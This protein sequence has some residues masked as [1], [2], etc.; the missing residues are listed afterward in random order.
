MYENIKEEA[1]KIIEEGW[2]DGIAVL[3]G[4]NKECHSIYSGTISGT[5]FKPVS[6]NTVYDLASVTKIF[7]LICIL[8]LV[9]KGTLSL[10]ACVGDYSALFPNISGLKIYE[11]MNFSKPL[12]TTRRIDTANNY[13]EAVSLLHNVQFVDESPKYSDMG[14]IILSLILNEL[15]GASFRE[16]LSE[17]KEI[18]N[19]SNTFFWDEFTLEYA[20]R[21]QSYDKEYVFKDNKLITKNTPIG[22]PHDPKARI[23]GVCGHAGIFSTP[24]NIATFCQCL[25]SGKIVAKNTLSLVCS[26]KY[27]TFIDEQHFGLLCYKKSTNIK[28]SEVPASFSN[29]S[30]AIFG[31]TGTYI[32]ID[33]EY[34]K[35]ITI[36]SNRIY[37]R[38]TSSYNKS[39]STLPSTKDYVYRKDILT[40]ILSSY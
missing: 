32:L 13:E 16:V 29:S 4:T 22:I 12:Q 10:N 26:T 36:N 9:E 8:K 7:F 40:N 35:F 19:L 2:T 20:S 37:K 11:L 28:K 18:C 5:D 31:F 6:E 30:F 27:D 23:L 34:S 17:I 33:P 38:C 21:T 39:L 1:K 3:W 25:L 24:E 15:P 14:A